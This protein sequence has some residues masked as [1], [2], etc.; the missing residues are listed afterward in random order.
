M[1]TSS[2]ELIDHPLHYGGKDDPYE[3]VKV[4]E[5]WYGLEGLKYFCLGSNLKYLTRAGK[6]DGESE[7]KDLGKAQGYIDYYNERVKVSENLNKE[8]I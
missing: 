5:A 1:E 3:T 2:K 6:K 4:I 8:K 7:K